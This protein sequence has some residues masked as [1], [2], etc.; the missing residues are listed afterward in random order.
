MYAIAQYENSKCLF[1]LIALRETVKPKFIPVLFEMA[2]V[3]S[4]QQK[5]H[6]FSTQWHAYSVLCTIFA[7]G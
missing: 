3:K 2:I 7:Y 1:Y 5:S 4:G 6:I